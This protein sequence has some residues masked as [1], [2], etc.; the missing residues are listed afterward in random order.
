[1]AAGVTARHFGV[2][3]DKD[4]R[5]STWY[6]HWPWLAAALS[7]VL[8]ALCFPPCDIGGLSFIALGPLLFAVWLKKPARRSGW[9]H[10]RLGYIT[11]LV[12]FTTTFS[13]LSELAGL[14]DSKMLVGLPLLLA[15]FLALYPATWAWFAGWFVG[16]HFKPIPRPDPTE[17]FSRPPLLYST[18]NLFFSL[19]IAALWTTLEWV[20]GW[21]LT[22][23]GWNALGVS[24]HEELALIQI[25]E[26]TGV[27]GLS[28]LLVLCNAIGVIT[29]L[30]LRAEIGRVRLRPHFDF[31]LTV[32]LV[33]VVFSYG[34]RVLFS[35][36][37]KAKTEP[38]ND[39]TSLHVVALQPN[40]PQK[41]K[42]EHGHEGEIIERLREL[43][44][45]AS[46]TGPHLVL[47][48]EAVVPGGMFSDEETHKF[49]LELAAQVPALLLGTDDNDRG[50]KGEDHNSAAL[51]LS[52]E[53][54]VQ[55]YDKRHLVPF[56]E[57]LPLRWALG[58][59]AGYLVPGDFKPGRDVG[60]FKLK[61]PALTLAPLVCFEDTLGELTR[62]PVR[63]GAQ[64][65]VNITND[66][67][68]G[69]SCE[70]EQHF[71]NSIFRAVENRRPL[72]RC[73]N[74]GVTASVDAVGRVEKWLG[75]FQKGFTSKHIRIPNHGTVTFYTRHGEVFSI[76]CAIISIAAILLR[77]LLLRRRTKTA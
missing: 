1:M 57:Y 60:L 3:N 35:E 74:T 66:G 70:P 63:R 71:V 42:L 54:D 22:G 40:I 13:W 49:V 4:S 25:V 33:V 55:L 45:I 53:K 18:R 24:L 26:F 34:A 19:L 31:S 12:F 17:P 27:G 61:E 75:P 52:G 46:L 43:H 8:L 23:F 5:P 32:A 6:R 67:W 56:G 47:W 16:E 39:V 48:P 9:Y 10:F 29:L 44:A 15:A 38:K 41:W 36:Q 28:F 37:T 20:R 64:V 62:E 21:L 50:A 69:R 2:M 14:F 51:L 77:T 11:G 30:R 73:T 68:F 76:I 7:G 72:I 58:W 65:L 59:I